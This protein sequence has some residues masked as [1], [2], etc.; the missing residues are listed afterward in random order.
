MVREG[1]AVVGASHH[2]PDIGV[3]ALF[4]KAS[5][6]GSAFFLDDGSLV[7]NRFG[8]SNITDELFD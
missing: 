1:Q 8:R 7:G 3:V 6:D 4:T 2:V 5:S